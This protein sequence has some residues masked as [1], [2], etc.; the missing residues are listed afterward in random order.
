MEDVEKALEDIK[1]Q[2]EIETNNMV[3]AA[4]KLEELKRQANALRA[5]LNNIK[6]TY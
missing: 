2:I 4:K 6:Y 3:E 5:I 1:K